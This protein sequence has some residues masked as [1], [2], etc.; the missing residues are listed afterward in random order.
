MKKFSLAL[1][2][3][4][5]LA[6]C[7]ERRCVNT[8]PVFDKSPIDGP[9]YNREL[10]KVLQQQGGDGVRYWV[11][12]YIAINNKHYME[13]NVH[14]DNLCAKMIFGIGGVKRLDNFITIAGESYSGAELKGVTYSVDSADGGVHFVMTGLTR[15]ID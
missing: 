15:I 9:Q 14:G 4:L 10:L 2:L 8:N 12:R 11:S 5:P 7:D 6:S 13:V 3:L 1:I